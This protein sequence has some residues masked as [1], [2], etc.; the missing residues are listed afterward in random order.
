MSEYYASKGQLKEL[1]A[2]LTQKF[3]NHLTSKAAQQWIESPSSIEGLLYKLHKGPVELVEEQKEYVVAIDPARTPEAWGVL[4]EGVNHSKMHF[5]SQTFSRFIRTVGEKTTAIVTIF[6]L[7]CPTN[8]EHAKRIREL[9]N[10]NPAGFEHT[11][12]LV[13]QHS[14]NIWRKADGLWLFNPDVVW[15]EKDGARVLGVYGDS[16]T[17]MFSSSSHLTYRNNDVVW[18]CGLKR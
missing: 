5:D 12:A 2:L 17:L 15:E 16:G 6:R 7:S 10:L 3:P 11:A 1:C 4:L 13:E 14:K 18:F 9:L 8:I